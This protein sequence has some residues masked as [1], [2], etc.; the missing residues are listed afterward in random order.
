MYLPESEIVEYLKQQEQVL[1]SFSGGKDS[2]A[3]WEVL[4]HYKI[5][6]IPFYMEIVPGLSFVRKA[7][8]HCEEHFKQHVYIT[9]HPDFY[10]MLR[11]GTAQPLHRI[12]VINYLELPRFEYTDV[13][14]G[15]CIT[16]G[17]PQDTVVA[18]GIRVR[19]SVLRRMRI[20]HWRIQNRIYPIWQATKQDVVNILTQNKTPVP[21]DY[22]M[23]GRSFD[24]IDY[25]FLEPIRTDYPE[26]YKKIL[27]WF[28]LQRAELLRAKWGVKHGQIKIKQPRD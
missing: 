19:D 5:K 12:P 10:Q 1:L 28:P 11:T 17:V 8:K 15:V 7:I 9:V 18:V 14:K 23:F 3:L 26:D 27:E 13:A 2:L 21:D 16:A 25:R 24:G 6:V 4:R 22:R 20:K